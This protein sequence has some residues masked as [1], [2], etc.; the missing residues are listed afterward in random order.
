[1]GKMAPSV[2]TADDLIR[3]GSC[4]NG[5]YSFLEE[6]KSRIRAAMPVAEALKIAGVGSNQEYVLKAAELTGDGNSDGGNGNG[7]GDGDGNGYGDGGNGN[8]YGGYGDGGYGNGYG[9]GNGYGDGGYGNGYGNG[10]GYGDGNGYGNSDGGNGN[11]YGDGGYG[12][13]YGYY[14]DGDG[15]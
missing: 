5:V 3:T 13:G 10:N 8:G 14:G 15:T 7:Y 2:I 9:N 6:N 4:A 1:M 11:G 12:N